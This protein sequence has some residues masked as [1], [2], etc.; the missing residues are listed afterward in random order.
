[1]NAMQQRSEIE[2]DETQ[3]KAI[4]ACCDQSKRVVPITGSAGTGKTTIM[5]SVYNTWTARGK[6][7]ALAAPTGKAA[8]RIKEATGI[9]AVTIHRLLEYPMP[10]EIDEN[11]GKRL[12]TSEPKRDRRNPLEYHVVMVDEYAM[13]NQEVH[14]NLLDALP[15]GGIVRMFGDCNQ[16]SPIETNKRLK[17]K[18]S[19]FESLLDRFDGIWLET[20]HR[21]AEDSTIITNGARIING[22]V[23]AKTAD[24]SIKVTEDP[25][26]EVTGMVTEKLDEGV[27]FGALDNQIITATHKGWIGTVAL[28]GTIQALLQPMD[29]ESFDIQRHKWDERSSLRLYQDDKVIFNVN[30]YDL[31][32]FN[33]ET[34]KVIELD[35]IGQV[36]VDF[37]DRIVAIPPMLEAINR[38]GDTVIVNPQKD[39]D[40]AY[41]ITTHKSQGS[42]YQRVCYVINSSRGF[43]LNRRNFYTAISR[44]RKNVYLITNQKALTFSLTRKKEQVFNKK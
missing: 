11:T 41:V 1:M 31:G 13:V 9:D 10:G 32:V 17:E 15:N 5:Q 7:V 24:F 21:Q 16:L 27:D 26:D 19:P 23:P 25:V 2:F 3:A 39:L 30:N 33:G 43:N 36:V 40:L 22:Q 12:G 4:R 34:G 29:K 8:K 37:G 20:I 38:N 42:E 6:N 18:P 44:A 35:A 14:R 28:N